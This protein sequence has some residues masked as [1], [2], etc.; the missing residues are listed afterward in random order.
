MPNSDR[1]V[2]ETD[3]SNTESQNVPETEISDNISETEGNSN[4]DTSHDKDDRFEE[5]SESKT[6]RDNQERNTNSSSTNQHGKHLTARQRRLMKKSKDDTNPASASTMQD[7]IDDTNDS[8]DMTNKNDSNRLENSTDNSSVNNNIISKRGNLNIKNESK[9][10]SC[11]KSLELQPETE[12]NESAQE[13]VDVKDTNTRKI[14]I[15]K[16]KPTNKKKAR[17]FKKY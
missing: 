9:A 16:K 17:R 10:L 7:T 11:A 15:S 14:E 13:E 6:T 2:P 1:N 12:N 5:A 8:I 4:K 3:R